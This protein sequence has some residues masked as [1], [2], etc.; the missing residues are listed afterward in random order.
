MRR[1]LLGLAGIAVVV[2]ALVGYVW[3]TSTTD[4]TAGSGWRLV[5]AFRGGDFAFTPEAR[6]SADLLTDDAAL[7]VAWAEA[8]GSGPAPDPDFERH[9]VLQATT[10]GSGSCPPHFDGVAFHDD[11]VALS[12]S[13]GIMVGG[14]TADAV[15]STFFLVV[16]RAR[17]PNRP[18]TV[19]IEADEMRAEVPIPSG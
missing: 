17:L 7:A 16:E 14:C 5:G 11:S 8:G 1:I 10:F 12:A 4:A 18:Y 6:G 9:A 13:R 3:V 15:P 2:A 19:R